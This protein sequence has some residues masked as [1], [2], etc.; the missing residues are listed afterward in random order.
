MPLWVLSVSVSFSWQKGKILWLSCFLMALCYL[1]F[2]VNTATID[3]ENN[4]TPFL[5][6]LPV[7]R[8]TYVK[9][10][11][12]LS[13]LC[14]CAAWLLSVGLAYLVHMGSAQNIPAPASQY[15]LE[16]IVYLVFV[17][18]AIIL[19]IRLK[20]GYGETSKSFMVFAL[21]ALVAMICFG[22]EL[23]QGIQ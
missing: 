5:L 15:Y 8:T 1:L 19:P 12:F 6:T 16:N 20:Y 21:L 4:G 13:G 9:E 11:Y 23:A 3:D 7:T 2:A 17:M 22:P 14:L 18:M 10:K